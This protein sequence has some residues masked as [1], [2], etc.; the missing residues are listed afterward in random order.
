MGNFLQKIQSGRNFEYFG[1]DP[2]LAA[3]MIENYVVGIQST[4]T[5]ATL[6]HFVCYN[7]DFHRRRTY[8]YFCNTRERKSYSR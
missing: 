8:S 4:G 1:E 7:T 6:K 2:F 3:R 5:I